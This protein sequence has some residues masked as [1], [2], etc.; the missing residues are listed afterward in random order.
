MDQA[1]DAAPLTATKR[2]A[3]FNSVAPALSPPQPYQVFLEPNQGSYSVLHPGPGRG[4]IVRKGSLDKEL[5]TPLP[6]SASI[7]RMYVRM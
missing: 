7:A 5:T 3:S 6:L 4:R 1:L 2:Q